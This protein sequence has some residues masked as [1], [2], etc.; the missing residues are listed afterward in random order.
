MKILGLIDRAIEKSCVGVLVAAVLLMIFFSIL[1][2]AL[3][4][5]SITLL[6]V[7]PFLRH[8]VFLSAFLG[9]AIATGNGTHI[10]IDVFSR[11][12]ESYGKHKM[13]NMLATFIYFIST[14]ISLVLCKVGYDFC[15][16]E[17]EFGHEIFI[18]ITSG[19]AVFSIPIGFAL[20]AYRYF[21]LFLLSIVSPEKII[22]NH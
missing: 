10:G 16:V 1:V 15:L 20:M 14:V 6:W 7:D 5:F 22:K 17:L 21:Y 3:R 8:L 4:P 13:K 12:L 19:Q 18:G 2:I 11:M 9:G